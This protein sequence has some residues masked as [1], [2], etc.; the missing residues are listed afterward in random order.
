[1]N[2]KSPRFSKPALKHVPIS[3]SFESFF[4]KPE[5]SEHDRGIV[6]KYPAQAV[7][8]HQGTPSH[9]VYLIEHG[10]VKLVRAMSKGQ[11]IIVGLRRRHWLIGAPAVILN[12][13]Y[14][15]MA[16]T[17]VPSSLRYIQAQDFLDLAKTNAQFSW[18]VH[19]LLAQQ[20]FEQMKNAEA[21][22]CMSSQDRMKYF[23]CDMMDEQKL[24]GSGPAD[25]SLPLTNKELA[26]LLAI[27]PEHLCRVLKAMEQKGLISRARGVITVTAP[28]GLLKQAQLSADSRSNLTNSHR[29][30]NLFG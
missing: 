25:F 17:L 26:Q 23:L 9:A 30:K 28:S 22:T 1:M 27:T 24:M 16:I 15:F 4:N 11:H 13:P 8:F 2:K 6:Q 10:L 3:D 12:K 20:I 14:S 29:V 21:M 5:N 18:N 19:Q 7:I